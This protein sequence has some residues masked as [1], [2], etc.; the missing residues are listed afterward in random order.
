MTSPVLKP[1]IR[2]LPERLVNKIA[3]GE[4]IERPAAVVKELVENSL[5]AS[6]DRIEIH[7]EKSGSKIIKIIDNGCGISKEQI[8]IAFSRHATS[9]IYNFN[10][11]EKL[12]SY[13]FRGE[14]LPSIASVARVRMISRPHDA[15]VATEIIYEG[16]VLQSKQPVAAPPGTTVEVENLFYNTPARRKFLKAE[17]TESRHISRLVTALAIGR[18]DIAFTF[19]VNNK[20]I[21]SLPSKEKLKDRVTA[22]LSPGREFIALSGETDEVKVEAV[23][24][25]PD[26]AQ[27]T[28]L[29]QYIFVNGRFI[30]SPSLSHAFMSGYGELLPR[31]TYPVGAL[32]LSVRPDEID[33]NVHPSKTE[34][35][36]AR[37][38]EIYNAVHHLIK[39]ALRQEGVVPVFLPRGIGPVQTEEKSSYNKEKVPGYGKDKIIPG[40]MSRFNVNKDFLRELYHPSGVQDTSLDSNIVRVDKTTGEIIEN[41]AMVYSSDEPKASLGRPSELPR[42]IRNMPAVEPEEISLTGKFAD[43][44][45]LCKTGDKLFIIDQH[46][47]HERILY[48]EILRRLDNHPVVAQQL[49]FPVPVEL[50]PEQL[51]CFEEFM[52]LI[53]RSGFTVSAFGGRMVNIEAVPTI[54]GGK[55]PELIIRQILDDL[56]ALK[57]AGQDIKKAMAQSLACRAA[58]M[59]GDHLSDEEALGLVR[60]LMR[61]ENPYSCPHGRP[62]FI[63]VTREDL[64]RQFGRC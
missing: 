13:G 21:F 20:N 43:L 14:A 44:Y 54:L 12:V 4:V 52:D 22:L 41:Q 47:A 7:I 63:K 61:C 27:S 36:L 48:E 50:S 45:L 57:K 26:L 5:D 42:V 24:G 33:V 16:G 60:Q 49:L 62:T 3:A 55:A 1:W 23:I 58:V 6:A 64:D 34:I 30:Y 46:A 37:E 11:L 53:N 10:D 35:K 31:G 32:L 25:T 15:E 59:A 39:E 40:P 18:Y 2:P 38:K 19:T 8:E 17:I 51:A 9:K 29:G 28:R 56:A